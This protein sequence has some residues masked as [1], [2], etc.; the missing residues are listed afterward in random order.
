LKTLS[1]QGFFLFDDPYCL[2]LFPALAK[3]ARLLSWRTAS[4]RGQG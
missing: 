4:G 1:F 3:K 2:M